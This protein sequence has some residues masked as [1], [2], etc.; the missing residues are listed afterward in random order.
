MEYVSH[1]NGEVRRITND[2]NSYM[3]V[4]LAA[5]SN[6][7]AA[8]QTKGDIDIWVAS[9]AEVDR[10]K[11]IT[12]DGHSGRPAWGPEARIIYTKNIGGGSDTMM[13][14]EADGTNPKQLLEESAAILNPRA[15]PDLHHIV[16]LS[17]RSGSVHLWRVDLD[18]NNLAQLTSSEWD[19]FYDAPGFSP[20]GKSVFYGKTG[21]EGGIWKVPMEGGNPVCMFAAKGKDYIGFPAISPDGKML[22]FSYEDSSASP[23][24]GVAILSLESGLVQRRFE[25]PEGPVQWTIDGH[26][27]LFNKSDAGVSNLWSQPAKE[28]AATQI[29]HFNDEMIYDFSMSRDGKRLLMSRGRQSSDVVLIRDVK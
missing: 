11:P 3:G 29:T 7:L 20:D 10:A 8:V 26:A 9:L 16:F 23:T 12:S 14:T 4:S 1:K 24:T 2:P 27:L 5:N 6:R 22:A 13:S 18:G 19:S 15:S 25:I 17:D 21:A 28:G